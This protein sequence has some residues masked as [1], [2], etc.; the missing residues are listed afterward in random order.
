MPKA[1]PRI[2]MQSGCKDYATAKGYCATHQT[3]SRQYDRLRGNAH[4]R[5]YS[6]VWRKARATYLSSH[7]LCVICEPQNRVTPACVVDHV[8]PHKGDQDLFW[9]STNWQ[10]LCQS[11][12]NSKTAKEDMGSWS[13][14]NKNN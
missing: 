13:S 1:A 4:Q 10:A 2:C 5:G 7:P 14:T 3:E 12:H 8:Q 6:N 11:C 9:D